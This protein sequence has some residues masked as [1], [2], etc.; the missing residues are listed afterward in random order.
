M[1]KPSIL[2]EIMQTNARNFPK[3][4]VYYFIIGYKRSGATDE[5]KTGK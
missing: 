5:R 1:K 3:T 4:M 2:S